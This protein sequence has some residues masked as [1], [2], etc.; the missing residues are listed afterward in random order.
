MFHLPQVKCHLTSIKNSL[1]V[2]YRHIKM[3]NVY[4]KA[5]RSVSVC[6]CLRG[7]VSA[8]MCFSL[9]L[10]VCVSVCVCLCVC[11]SV[12][13]YL[14]EYVHSW[15]HWASRQ[16]QATLRQYKVTL[17]QMFHTSLFSANK[18]VFVGKVVKTDHMALDNGQHIALNPQETIF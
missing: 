7:S 15:L 17:H 6:T 11:I 12:F 18:T 10:C 9:S 5:N 13:P 1:H 8:K 3:T 4:L 16:T 2:H 14:C